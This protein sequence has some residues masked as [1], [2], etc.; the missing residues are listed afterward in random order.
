MLIKPAE[1]Q[2][3]ANSQYDSTIMCYFLGVLFPILIT[4]FEKL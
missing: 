1:R 4:L 3:V 2:K